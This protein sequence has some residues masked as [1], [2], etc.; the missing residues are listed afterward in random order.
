M[1]TKG[2][3]LMSTIINM[4]WDE[5]TSQ[6]SA[7]AKGRGLGDCGTSSAWEWDDNGS[8][9]NFVLVEERWKDDCDGVYD[10]WPLIWPVQ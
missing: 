6:L 3:T 9:G 4:S 2:P 10:D 7:Y 8:Y 5:K 1:G